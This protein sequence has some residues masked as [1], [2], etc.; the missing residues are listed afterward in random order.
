[1]VTCRKAH[2]YMDTGGLSSISST[3]KENIQIQNYPE[4]R[5]QHFTDMLD[6]DRVSKR[7]LTSLFLMLV[8]MI[9][10]QTLWKHCPNFT[11]NDYLDRRDI[12]EINYSSQL[13]QAE[14]S[15]INRINK[16]MTQYKEVSIISKLY[17]KAF[18]TSSSDSHNNE[19]SD[20]MAN[21]IL[22]H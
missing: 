7:Y 1:M 4:S 18:K 16:Y 13:P 5:F 8:W 3:P 10:P 12:T 11:D 15:N 17:K 21:A 9:E 6:K 20:Y 14:H 22:R 19:W 2:P